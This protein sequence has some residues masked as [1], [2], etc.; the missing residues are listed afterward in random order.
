MT[1]QTT[2]EQISPRVPYNKVRNAGIDGWV[3][4]VLSVISP[5]VT[6]AT[7]VR[8]IL[9]PNEVDVGANGVL[10][11]G[12][13][14]PY[15]CYVFR[16]GTAYIGVGGSEVD[17]TGA[18]GTTVTIKPGDLEYRGRTYRGLIP[19]GVG[20]PMNT[21]FEKVKDSPRAV[22]PPSAAG[23]KPP[24]GDWPLLAGGDVASELPRNGDDR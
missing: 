13:L 24:A 8:A 20:A 23:K 16:G 10:I 6:R 3:R 5:R 22:S 14:L 12:S 15:G 21:A 9:G 11:D 18:S 1:L 2:Q 19:Y 4:K 7:H 17:I